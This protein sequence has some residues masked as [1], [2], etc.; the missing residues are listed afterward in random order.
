M[1][2]ADVVQLMETADAYLWKIARKYSS[3]L[4]PAED[5][6]Q[7]GL[8]TAVW[9]D[10]RSKADEG[11]DYQQWWLRQNYVWGVHHYARRNRSLMHVSEKRGT[12][13]PE[14]VLLERVFSDTERPVVTEAEGALDDGYL[15]AEAKVDCERAMVGLTERQRAVL[16]CLFWDKL[17]WDRTATTLGI[18]DNTVYRDYKEAIRHMRNALEGDYRRLL[19]LMAIGVGS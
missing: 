14:M 9:A 8:A 15:A 4:N 10:R 17:G 2:N 19:E 11:T 1:S 7:E 3:R 16:R 13:I 12:A 5:L 18:S 6:Y